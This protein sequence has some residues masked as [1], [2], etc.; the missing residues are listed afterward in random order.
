M[1]RNQKKMRWYIDIQARAKASS[2][3][4]VVG[5]SD[6]QVQGSEDALCDWRAGDEEKVEERGREIACAHVCL[7]RRQSDHAG[8]KGLL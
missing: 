3:L 4:P 8:L 1:N 5:S 6:W 2:K 7:C